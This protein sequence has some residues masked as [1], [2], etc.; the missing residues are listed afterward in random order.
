MSPKERILMLRL[1]E[2]VLHHKDYAER[3][4][5]EIIFEHKETDG[6][7]KQKKEVW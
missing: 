1:S 5:V 4:G 2:K 7:R 6:K 3:I